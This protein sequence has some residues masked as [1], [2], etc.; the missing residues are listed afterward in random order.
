[1]AYNMETLTRNELIELIKNGDD[2]YDNQIRV[3]KEGE[4]FLSRT[5]GAENISQLKW[6]YVNILDTKSQTFLC[7]FSR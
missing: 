4:I 1:M 3:T 2:N 7:S 6:S 5:V